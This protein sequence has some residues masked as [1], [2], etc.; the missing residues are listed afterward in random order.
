L[1]LTSL[2]SARSYRRP[3]S[4]SSADEPSLPYRL[5]GPPPRMTGRLPLVVFLHGAGERGRD[6][7]VQLGNGAAELLGRPEA[8]RRFPCFFVLPQCPPE[9]RWVEVD[10]T[11]PGHRLPAEPSQPLRQLLGLL[12]QLQ[13]ELPVA[14]DRIYLIGLSMGG[15][16]VW[17]LLSRCPQQFAAAV[18]ICGGGDERQVEKLRGQPLW[19]FH[20]ARDPVV[21]VERSRQM[22]HALRQLGSPP[23]PR[24]SELPEVGHDA[25]TPAFAEPELLPWLFAQ[26]RPP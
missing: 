17:D 8:R 22:I 9:S 2:F 25:W 19:A 7:S 23:L 14:V 12:A 26:R 24:Y 11:A 10:W 13:A 1:S 3:R 15:F 18:P 6:N 20:G 4:I 21:A 16:G 5:L